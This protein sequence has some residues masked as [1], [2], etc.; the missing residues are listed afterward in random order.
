MSA[1]RLQL[2]EATYAAELE[3]GRQL[4]LDDAVAE[5]L[6]TGSPSSAV[7]DASRPGRVLVHHSSWRST[8]DDELQEI[9]STDDASSCPSGR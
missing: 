3:S 4:S 2:G 7:D 5:A 8:Y 9:R 1:A 6:T